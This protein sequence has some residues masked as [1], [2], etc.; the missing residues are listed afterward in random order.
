MIAQLTS[1]SRRSYEKLV[2]SYVDMDEAGRIT[3]SAKNIMKDKFFIHS[4]GLQK[5]LGLS[6]NNHYAVRACRFYNRSFHHCPERKVF[7]SAVVCQLTYLDRFLQES[8]G[9]RHISGSGGSL[10]SISLHSDQKGGKGFLCMPEQQKRWYSE[11]KIVPSFSRDLLS[12]SSSL[13]NY[14]VTEFAIVNLKG[15]INMGKSEAS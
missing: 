13:T 3:N 9:F 5:T 4:H 14:V 12:V 6:S 15:P 11:S 7:L 8:I 10:I 2:D 1:K